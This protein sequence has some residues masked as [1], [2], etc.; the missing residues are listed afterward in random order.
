MM[1][2]GCVRIMSMMN[3]AHASEIVDADHRITIAG[4]PVEIR[5]ILE[6]L[7]GIVARPIQCAMTRVRG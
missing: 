1:I 7:V 3:A 4:C 6:Q 2:I 5:L